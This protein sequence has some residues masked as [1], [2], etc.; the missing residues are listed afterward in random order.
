MVGILI[1][2]HSK[3]A[4]EGVLELAALMAPNIPIRAVGGTP[5]GGFGTSYDGI[6]ESINELLSDDGVIVIGDIGSTIMTARLLIDDMEDEWGDRVR[7]VDC[8]I[9]EGA[10]AAAIAAAGG[11]DID[12]V[13]AA[14]KEAGITHK[15]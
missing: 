15:L 7:L 2:S 14:A 13:I 11:A 8:P 9:L 5:D 10:V 6:C 3:K 12:E 1:V 4:A